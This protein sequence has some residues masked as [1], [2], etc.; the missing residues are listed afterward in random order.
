[1]T[2]SLVCCCFSEELVEMSEGESD[3]IDHQEI[4]EEERVLEDTKRLGKK[5]K[6]TKDEDEDS[7]MT[8][9]PVTGGWDYNPSNETIQERDDDTNEVHI[10]YYNYLFIY[11]L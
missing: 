3:T 10:N 4:E 6:M 2:P 5:R 8:P 7:S 9:L 1:M 11:F